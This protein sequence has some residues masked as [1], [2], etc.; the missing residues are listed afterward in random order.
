MLQ[1][2]SFTPKNAPT[3]IR[4]SI[5]NSK[6]IYVYGAGSTGQET[7]NALSQKGVITQAVLDAKATHLKKLN[8]LPVYHPGNDLFSAQHKLESLVII[9]IFNAFTDMRA[10]HESLA[11][12]GWNNL[13]TFLDYYEAFH[14]FYKSKYWLTRR[15]FYQGCERLINSALEMFCD[16]KSRIL[17]T[18]TLKFRLTG[19]YSC[20]E[21]SDPET[22]YFPDDIPKDPRPLRIADC[23][24]FDGDTFDHIVTRNIPLEAYAGFEPDPENFHKLVDRAENWV[25]S[26]SQS[27]ALWPCGVWSDCT[28]LSFD[29][30]KQAGSAVS[31]TGGQLIQMVAL[32]QAIRFF[33]PTMIKMD[34]EGAELQALRGAVG[35]I[36]EAVPKLA[37]CVYHEPSH[38]WSIPLFIQSLGLPYEY[39]LRSHCLNGFDLVF[40]ATPKH[41]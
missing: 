29:S 32:D 13:V 12:A 18:Q 24:A 31:E 25:S 33:S 21:P 41:Q 20:L 3:R 19:D 36:R 17:F 34:I 4:T 5:L 7:V 38:L 16:E 8:G 27:L 28:Q 11:S 23:G 40:Y 22:Q 6:F 30:G 2:N 1:I 14:E 9:A 10:V 15:D 39:Y 37:I 26:P 35:L